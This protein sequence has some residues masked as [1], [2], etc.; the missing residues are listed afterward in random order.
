ML[1]KMVRPDSKGRITLG[2]LA[3]GVSGFSMTETTDHKI[4]L[5]PYTEIPASEKW[6]FVNKKALKMVEQG[7]K[8]TAAGRLVEK[9]S[10][11]KF[12]N[13]DID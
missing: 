9:G 2:H 12:S 7:L 1:P 13:D 3:D 6:L 4:I 10:F 11:A 5:I 8:D